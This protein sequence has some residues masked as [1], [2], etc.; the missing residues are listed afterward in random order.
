MICKQILLLS[1]AIPFLI[2]LAV[3]GSFAD[4]SNSH[5]PTIRNINSKLEDVRNNTPNLLDFNVLGD[6]YWDNDNNYFILTKPLE[7]QTGR[8]FLV[9]PHEMREWMAEFEIRIWGGGGS[10]NGADGMTF[11]FVRSYDYPRVVGGSL[12]FGGEGYGVGFNTYQFTDDGNPREQHIGLSKDN[13]SNKLTITEIPGGI[14]DNAWHHVRVSFSNGSISVHYDD[15]E[16]ISSY[17]IP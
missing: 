15:R 5:V 2:L 6:A 7:D 3:A 10:G 17:S 16:V 9:S 13:I 11:A 1:L 14:K 8:I 12:D 4:I